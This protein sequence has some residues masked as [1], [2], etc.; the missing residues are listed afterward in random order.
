MIIRI[1]VS[2]RAAKYLSRMN[3]PHKDRL[4]SGIRKLTNEP[5][6]GDIKPMQGY[7]D[8]TQRLRVGQYRIIHKFMVENGEKTLYIM[9]IGSRGDIYK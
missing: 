4:L 5:P 7:S 1:E 3:Q 2:P 9:D 6:E 8:G